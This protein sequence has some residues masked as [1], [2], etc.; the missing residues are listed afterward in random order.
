[1]ETKCKG[2]LVTDPRLAKAL[3]KYGLSFTKVG[4]LIGAKRS[5]TQLILYGH[6]PISRSD[7]DIIE[8]RVKEKNPKFTMDD[9]SFKEEGFVSEDGTRMIQCRR[10]G[11]WFR[12]ENARMRYCSDYCRGY[13]G[14]VSRVSHKAEKPCQE[15][16]PEEQDIWKAEE[17]TYE[18]AKRRHINYGDV[19]KERTLKAE[20]TVLQRWEAYQRERERQCKA[21]E[22]L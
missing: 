21:S 1:M 4:K 6:Y 13:E 18:E 5:R 15:E 19:Q 22:S 14:Y 17:S 20:P 3:S 8:Q 7:L 12:P 2:Y 11:V 16:K 9:F 10:C